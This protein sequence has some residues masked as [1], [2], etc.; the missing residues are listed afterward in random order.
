MF[1]VGGSSLKSCLWGLKGN[2]VK[3]CNH[4]DLDSFNHP[5]AFLP[6]HR[7]KS[8]ELC[9][10]SRTLSTPPS[11]LLFSKCLAMADVA[12]ESI[13]QVL[14]ALDIFSGKPDKESL[15]KA[16]AWLQNFQHAVSSS[17]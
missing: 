5:L 4:C 8:H 9:S 13:Q 2:P 16:N 11:I 14:A 6:H 7:L 15:D 12:N 17:L 3:P 10:F 1:R